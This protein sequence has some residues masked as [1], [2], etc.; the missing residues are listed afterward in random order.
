MPRIWWVLGLVLVGCFEPAEAPSPETDGLPDVSKIFADVSRLRELTSQRVP[1]TQF[2]R[3]GQYQ[4]E[5]K[6]LGDAEHDGVDTY[7]QQL[8]LAPQRMTVRDEQARLL[9]SDG[10]YVQSTGTI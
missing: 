3:P 6:R 9:A 5:T 10:V 4:A 2:L 1:R 7:A 8:G